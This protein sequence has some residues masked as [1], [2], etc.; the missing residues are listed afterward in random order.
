[1]TKTLLE[2]VRETQARYL[3]ASGGEV[4]HFRSYGLCH[5]CMHSRDIPPLHIRVEV[6]ALVSGITQKWPAYSGNPAY[7]VPD[8]AFVYITNEQAADAA[9]RAYRQAT[10][11][12]M[13]SGKYGKLRMQLA[14][15]I[16]DG[17]ENHIK[18]AEGE[19]E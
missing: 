15:F 13:Y 6:K 2:Y 17:L 16:A 9:A 5:N 3:K 18:R 7:P 4:E 1:M 10:S 14:A 19:C 8:P 12:G 11:G